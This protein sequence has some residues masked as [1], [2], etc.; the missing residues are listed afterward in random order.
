MSTDH[1]AAATTAASPPAPETSSPPVVTSTDPVP[2]EVVPEN[3]VTQTVEPEVL[4]LEETH[5]TESTAPAIASKP[6]MK[7]ISPPTLDP[8][9]QRDKFLLKQHLLSINA[10]YDVVDEDGEE[11]MYVVR[12]TYPIRQGLSAFTAVFVGLA[13][14]IALILVT[15]EA[16]P[17]IGDVGAVVLAL[18]GILGVVLAVLLAYAITAPK[19]HIT[20]YRNK[21]KRET[22]LTVSQ[23]QKITLRMMRYTVRDPAGIE[24]GRYRKDYLASFLRKRWDGFDPE[25]NL[26]CIAR[27]DSI[28]LSLFRR[29]FGSL[30]GLLKTNFIIHRPGFGSQDGQKLGEFIRKITILDRYILDMTDDHARKFD[31]RMAIVLGVLLDTGEGR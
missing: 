6:A 20:F 14:L 15:V 27:E 24:L 10:V 28:W 5:R 1:P 4:E 11:I 16:Q 21:D 13:G 23:D 30:Y 18:L 17:S 25:G 29:L 9:F 7:I 2:A 26:V 8:V 22:L 31:R 19:R 3:I 12:P